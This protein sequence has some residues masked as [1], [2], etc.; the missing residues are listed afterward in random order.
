MIRAAAITP[1]LH[2]GMELPV[3]HTIAQS[4]EQAV[5]IID[6]GG[7]ALVTD[8]DL[9]LAILRELGMANAEAGSRVRRAEHG[10]GT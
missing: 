10:L 9:A 6:A 2:L 1:S 5:R 4:V 3:E 8:T 7:I